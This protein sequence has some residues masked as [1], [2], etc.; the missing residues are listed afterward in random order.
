MFVNN[1]LN[2]FYECTFIVSRT[3]N[4]DIYLKFRVFNAIFN[5][6]KYLKKI[7]RINVYFSKDIVLK[8][9]NTASTKLAKYYSKIKE[10][11]DIL[12]NFVNILDFTQK[13]S[14]YKL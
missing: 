13:I 7:I 1:I 9:C 6:L 3:I 10:L 2:F 12:Y 14:L 8:I 4:I 5:Y 11:D